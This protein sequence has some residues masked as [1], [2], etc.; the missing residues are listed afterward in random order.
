MLGL[1]SAMLAACE[2]AHVATPSRDPVHAPVAGAQP[3]ASAPVPV[4][5]ARTGSV[6]LSGI[7]TSPAFRPVD[8]VDSLF[9]RRLPTIFSSLLYQRWVRDTIIRYVYC[10][11]EKGDGYPVY[12]EWA[13]AR[14]RLLSL[15]EERSARTRHADNGWRVVSAVVEVVRVGRLDS[16]PRDDAAAE[17]DQPIMSVGVETDTL[18]LDWLRRE[19][20]WVRCGSERAGPFT[21]VDLFGPP[22]V[23]AK[24]QGPLVERLRALADSVGRAGA[25]VSDARA[26]SATH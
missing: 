4:V 12:N 18:R 1:V 13:V 11:D 5:A 6:A 19:G 21:P 7:A 22:T 3:T 23:S 9:S 15:E 25:E 10:H 17:K 24:R 20:P 14:I 26:T 2:R 8:A 16:E